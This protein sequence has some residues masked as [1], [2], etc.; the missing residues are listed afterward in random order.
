MPLGENLK[1]DSAICTLAPLLPRPW[2]KNRNPSNFHDL[3]WNLKIQRFFCPK[4]FF[5]ALNDEGFSFHDRNKDIN[6]LFD[7]G[8]WVLFQTSKTRPVP[9][10]PFH[11]NIFFLSSFSP[12]CLL[13]CKKSTFWVG[14]F[15][16]TIWY[17]S[18]TSYDH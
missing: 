10:L 4:H 3:N 13:L 8:G 2:S 14:F 5:W 11:Y 16:T 1:I 7:F 18:T 6:S 9:S 15:G 12:T 17:L